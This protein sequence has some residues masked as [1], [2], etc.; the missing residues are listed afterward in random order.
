V[1]DVLRGELGFS[2]LVVSDW[3]GTGDVSSDYPYA[4]RT[5]VNAGVDMVMV[6]FDYR[7]FISTLRDEVNAGRVTPARIDEAV[8]RIITKKLELGLFDSPFADR[9]LTATV[10]SAAHRAL[11]RRAVRESLVLLKNDGILP[12]GTGAR[13]IFVAGKNADDVGNQ[14]GGW[15]IEWQGVSGDVIPGT[16]ILQAIRARAGPGATVAYDRYASGL[17][18]TWDVAVVVIGEWPYAEWVGD[19]DASGLELDDQDTAALDAV[20]RSGVPAVV[21]VVSGRPLLVTNRLPD[22]RALVAAWLPGT[23]GAGVADV[24]FGDYAPTGKLPITWPRSGAQLPIHS[25]DPGANPLFPFGYGLGYGPATAHAPAAPQST[26]LRMAV[27]ASSASTTTA[28]VATRITA[29][30]GQ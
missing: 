12:L 27:T 23:E 1:T 25:G 9:T 29:T 15:T 11:A 10:G 4:V 14:S 19:R 26:R 3:W 6:P 21:V 22:W 5:I 17:D 2:G 18:A 7:G 8:T 16:S 24:L 28:K 30:R 13:R 20:R